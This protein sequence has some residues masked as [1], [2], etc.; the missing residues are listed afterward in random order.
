MSQRGSASGRAR[1]AWAAVALSLVALAV[2]FRSKPAP[3]PGAG[4]AEQ[5]TPAPSVNA[6]QS[7]AAERSV[8]APSSAVPLPSAAERSVDAPSSAPPLPSAAE[9][10]HPHPLTPTRVAQFRQADLLEG[11]LRA[12]DQRDFA[13]AR[14]LVATH[15]REFPGA[16]VDMNEGIELLAECLERPTDAVV[17]RAEKFYSEH[18]VSTLRRRLR[19]EC[20]EPAKRAAFDR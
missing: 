10:R 5:T 16:R 1:V 4:S 18:T 7:S 12:L 6:E 9:E 14:T 20:L 15:R 11:A 8:T 13:R 3:P 17:G 2:S 19:R